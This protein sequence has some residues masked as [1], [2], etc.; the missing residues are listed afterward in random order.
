MRPTRDGA[1]IAAYL[2]TK[3]TAVNFASRAAATT[4]DKEPPRAAFRP[5]IEADLCRSRLMERP[6]SGTVVAITAAPRS[7]P[8]GVDGPMAIGAAAVMLRSAHASSNL[9]HRLPR[10]HYAILIICRHRIETDSE[11]RLA[12]LYG[13]RNLLSDTGSHPLC[14]LSQTRT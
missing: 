2:D 11:V 9:F 4:T 6:D 3:Q 8:R 14:D 12:W 7:T 1:G 5:I 13:E 10:P